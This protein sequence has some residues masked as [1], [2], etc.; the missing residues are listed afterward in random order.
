MNT[1]IVGQQKKV[2]MHVPFDLKYIMNFTDWQGKEDFFQKT[3]TKKLYH[4]RQK[5]GTLS[6]R[7]FSSDLSPLLSIS[8]DLFV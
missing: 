2:N 5:G 1:Y 3:K 6:D 8:N 4:E 7:I